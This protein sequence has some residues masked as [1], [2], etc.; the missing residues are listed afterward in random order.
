[1]ADTATA[2]DKDHRG[3]T[4]RGHEQTIVIGAADHS[5]G[6]QGQVAAALDSDFDQPL[7]AKRRLVHVKSFQVVFDATPRTDFADRLFDPI[8]RRIAGWD[9]CVPQIYLEPGSIGNAVHRARFDAKDSRGSN[10]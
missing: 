4:N 9:L 8:E 5:F 1:M 3:G 6:R 7:V 10:S 2:R